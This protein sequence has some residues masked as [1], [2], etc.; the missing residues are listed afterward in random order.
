MPHS[1]PGSNV[2][3]T[4]WPEDHSNTELQD[5][6][7]LAL[8]ARARN[9]RDFYIVDPVTAARQAWHSYEQERWTMKMHSFIFPA[10]SFRQLTWTQALEVAITILQHPDE[11]HLHFRRY[12][13][14][15]QERYDRE[16]VT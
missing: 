4:D 16:V 15:E 3:L 10:H 11:P 2:M 9:I 12:D 7:L 13:E 1:Y 14:E 5:H 8:Q 6:T